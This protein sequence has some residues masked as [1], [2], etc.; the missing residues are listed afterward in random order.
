MRWLWLGGA[1]AILAALGGARSLASHPAAVELL[2]DPSDRAAFR[3]WFTFLAEIQFHRETAS[4]PAEIKDC[5][6][7][8]RFSYREALRKHD[9]RWAADLGLPTAPGFGV[10]RASLD[11]AGMFRAGDRGEWRHYADAR[12]LLRW[13][14]FRMSRD[15]HAA[16]PG[17][18][19]FYHQPDQASPFHVMIYLGASHFQPGPERYAVYH[20]GDEPGEI[21]RPSIEELAAHP[22]PRWRPFEGNGNFLGVYRWNIL[23][24]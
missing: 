4:L 7:L 5:A 2:R 9:G 23:A 14:S 24:D 12:T 19:L 17:D 20:T 3:G 15:L 6:A 1:V 8:V 22:N 21:R 10:I 13:N 18:L 16:R 11:H